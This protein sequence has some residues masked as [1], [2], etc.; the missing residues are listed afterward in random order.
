MN[1]DEFKK[2]MKNIQEPV[3]KQNVIPT[4]DDVLASDD[5]MSAIIN[6][7]KMTQPIRFQKTMAQLRSYGMI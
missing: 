5:I 3:K 4:L 1:M 2:N 7:K 6:R